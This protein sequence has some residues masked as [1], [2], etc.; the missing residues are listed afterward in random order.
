MRALSLAL[1]LAGVAA[2]ALAQA[3]APGTVT[4]PLADYQALQAKARLEA[5]RLKRAAESSTVLRA[6]H[7]ALTY[8]GAVLRIERRFDV[9]ARGPVFSPL[10]LPTLGLVESVEV[11]PPGG[12]VGQGPQG[13]T[14][15]AAAAGRHRIT[16]KSRLPLGG[17]PGALALELPAPLAPLADAELD[18]PADYHWEWPTA[19]LQA[20]DVRTPRRVVRAV[21]PRQA[22]TLVAHPVVPVVAESTAVARAVVI[23]LLR[24]ER[25]GIVRRDAVLYE[26]LRGELDRYEIGL[27]PGYE[28]DSWQT[29]DGTRST[30]D[31]G[32]RLLV[33]RNE[34][35]GTGGRVEI[36]HL[37]PLSAQ[38]EI[39]LSPIEPTVPV[40]ARY[41]VIAAEAPVKVNAL[42]ETGWSSIDLS[43]PPEAVRWSLGSAPLIAGARLEG[44]PERPRVVYERLPFAG[45]A[46]APLPQRRTMTH[47]QADGSILHRDGFTIEAGRTAFS[48]RLPPG[49]DLES[50]EVGG[51]TVRPVER[52]GLLHVPVPYREAETLVE[53]IAAERRPLP[54]GRSAATWSFA[55][56]EID[57]EVLV[58]LWSVFLPGGLQVG[59]KGG[60]LTAVPPGW[61]TPDESGLEVVAGERKSTAAAV[62]AAELQ[63][64]PTA[65]DPW[66]ILQQTP[67]VLTDRI[68]VGGNESGQ[69]STFIGGT[70]GTAVVIEAPALPSLILSAVRAPGKVGIELEVRALA[71]KKR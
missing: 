43:D 8:E 12:I 24:F 46:E 29:D 45:K 13:L 47:I 27:P 55:L 65:R 40:R 11:S 3:P 14:F 4:L 18:L 10:V 26:V 54:Q 23:T 63:K 51:E 36:E 7:L 15:E 1:L 68:N 62:S 44:R 52:G 16:V 69:Q 66:A 30:S 32:R 21:L 38:G 61:R 57:R 59:L 42:P 6:E 25:T 5:E 60:D 37:E 48:F 67:G 71:A 49:L 34:K 50:V 39:L 41:V 31:D 35:R 56:P 22:S 9:S 53:V 2:G 64:I 28:V 33:M 20:E 17:A 19:Q 70:S 58:H